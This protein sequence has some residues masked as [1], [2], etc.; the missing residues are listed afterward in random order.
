M[1][2]EAV[3]AIPAAADLYHD[4]IGYASEKTGRDIGKLMLHG[5]QEILDDTR[6]AQPVIFIANIVGSTALSQILETDPD[7]R[8]G[9]SFGHLAALH[10]EGVFDTRT[11]LDLAI[12][13]GEFM[14]QA[15]INRPGSMAAVFKIA[16]DRLTEVCRKYGVTWANDNS[17][18]EAVISGESE[19]VVAAKKE[20]EDIYGGRVIMLKVR[21]AAHSPLVQAAADRMSQ[22]AE[23]FHTHQNR[24]RL[25][26][27]LVVMS[28]RTVDRLRS[29]ADIKADIGG[30]ADRVEWQ[31]TVRRLILDGY[32]EFYETGPGSKLTNLPRRGPNMKALLDSHG[33]TMTSLDQLLEKFTG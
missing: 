2:Q 23:A 13:R 10:D 3:K 9:H 20:I 15:F 33:A 7:T 26:E 6:L 19:N 21:G 27:K 17:D 12:A 1:A 8:V 25:P 18:T 28:S 16:E 24:I 11:G 31:N 29:V 5:P 30:L 32:T 4:C 22:L 14:H